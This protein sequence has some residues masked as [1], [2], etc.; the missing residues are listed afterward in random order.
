MARR[1]DKSFFMADEVLFVGYSR[2]NEGFCRTV[3]EAFE[4]SGARVYPVNPNGGP[5]GVQ[6]YPSI[7][8]VPAKPK[9]AYVLTSK[10]RSAGE[11]E[12]LA[13][14]GVKRVLF[15]SRMSADDAILK[16]C[17]QLGMEAEI[18]CPLMALGGGLHRF[19]GFLSGVRA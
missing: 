12:T 13:A 8:S 7:G 14:Q 6:V 15:Q 16:R 4:R 2:K 10:A 3:K 1:I 19:H 18:A 17:A 9:L 11:V 5:G